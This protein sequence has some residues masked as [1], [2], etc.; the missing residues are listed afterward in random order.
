[1]LIKK[2]RLH[3]QVQKVKSAILKSN[4]GLLLM[5]KETIDCQAQWLAPISKLNC[6]DP[7]LVWLSTHTS[8]PL[9]TLDTGVGV[10]H[11]RDA[12]PLIKVTG[13]RSFQLRSPRTAGSARTWDQLVAIHR[14]QAAHLWLLVVISSFFGSAFRI[15]LTKPRLTEVHPPTWRQQLFWRR[16]KKQNT[17]DVLKSREITSPEIAK[18]FVV[19]VVAVSVLFLFCGLHLNPRTM[20]W[21]NSKKLPLKNRAFCETNEKL[22]WLENCTVNFNPSRVQ[23]CC[24]VQP[25][26]HFSIFFLHLHILI[27]PIRIHYLLVSYF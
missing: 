13:G 22:F 9:P 15:N 17:F 24:R 5:N 4:V 23:N 12:S 16:K 26:A 14:N 27:V 21:Y 2:K 7:L 11:G 3:V 6:T 20:I 8:P 25:V 19:I 18:I 1:M 10:W